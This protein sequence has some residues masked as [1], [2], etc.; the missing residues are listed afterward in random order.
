M[1]KMRIVRHHVKQKLKIMK[2]TEIET[3]TWWENVYY[4]VCL[5]SIKLSDDV[6]KAYG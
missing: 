2:I 6:F 4:S 3:E 1:K 5:Y